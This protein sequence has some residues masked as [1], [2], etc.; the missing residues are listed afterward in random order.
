SEAR[1]S[2]PGRAAARRGARV[3]RGWGS[4]PRRSPEPARVLPPASRSA[5]SRK[6]PSPRPRRRE[7]PR[8]GIAAG[9][10]AGPDVGAEDFLSVVLS[11][12]S[13]QRAHLVQ[14]AA[15]PIADP[16][17]EL[18]S[19]TRRGGRVVFE[20]RRRD[21]D[22]L[23]VVAGVEK[24]VEHVQYPGVRLRGAELVQDEQLGL[25]VRGQHRLLGDVRIGPEARLDPKKEVRKSCVES[26][27]AL[28]EHE[29]RKDRAGEVRLAEAGRT[30]QEE[31]GLD[32]R[33]RLRKLSGDFLRSS[34]LRRL[35]VEVRE[36]VV[37]ITLG[38]S[39][40][41]EPLLRDR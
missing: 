20:V 11:A 8:K 41:L 1:A 26:G 28:G 40:G 17:L 16:I 35:I 34:E 12:Q 13:D 6:P 7:V 25:G 21:R 37:A 14:P 31:A 19:L 30:D 2:E 27:D 33:V 32:G 38:N 24:V 5:R 18:L 23:A 22:P 10:K 29:L 36:V 4:A 3:A 15:Q 9:S 39:G